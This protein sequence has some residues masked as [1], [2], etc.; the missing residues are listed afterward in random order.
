MIFEKGVDLQ[1]VELH[2]DQFIWGFYEVNKDIPFTRK[3]IEMSLNYFN[4]FV[5]YN[6]HK[7]NFTIV[8]RKIF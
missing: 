3:V 8:E 7:F 4:K 6:R 2:V 5:L 1:N